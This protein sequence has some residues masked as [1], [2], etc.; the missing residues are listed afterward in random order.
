MEWRVE[1]RHGV[2][3]AAAVLAV[4][5]TAV[6]LAVPAA[7]APTVAAHLLIVDT[8]GFGVLF[9]V[10]LVLFERAEG[11]RAIL[12]AAPL[13]S[14]EYVG[15]KLG[16]LTC[17]AA[18]IAVP[19][20]LA[21]ARGR[22]G[23][24]SA[25]P[26]VL[27]GV[28]LLSLL[29]VGGVLAACG[30]SAGPGVLFTRLPLVAPLVAAPLVH[31]S[32]ALDH[33][34]LYL[35]P[36]TGGADLIR[37][38]LL[39]EAAPGA[40]PLAVAVLYLLVWIAGAAVLAGRAAGPETAAAVP[41]PGD[42]S[43]LRPELGEGRTTGTARARADAPAAGRVPGGTGAS[44]VPRRG[45]AVGGLARVDLRGLL[46][47]PMLVALLLGP[48]L[49]AL[50]LRWG[51]PP[52]S[53][54]LSDRYGLDTA[55]L[56]P[57][58]LAALVVLHVPMMIGAIAALRTVEDADDGTQ[59]LYRVS[60]LGLPR[61]L[62][63]RLAVASIAAAGGLAAAVPLSGLAA[64]V[65][66][67]RAPALVAAVALAALQAPLFVLAA[68][69]FAPSKIETLVLVKVAGA[70]FTLTPVAVWWLPGRAAWALAP[71]PLF[72]PTAVLPGFGTVPWP[73]GLAAGTV[74]AA[75][76]GAWLVRRTVRRLEGG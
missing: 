63:Y 47:D 8:A 20:T 52:V 2:P 17:L 74:V 5:W 33:P 62:A 7:S 23:A 14:A 32:G 29:L 59:L 9:A 10:V 3:A 18:A 51:Y 31:V 54:F 38:G 58:L 39:P 55:P 64:G 19:M 43:S 1:L 21:A 73:A 13:R 76:S 28:V 57:V 61:Y 34:L 65:P 41:P 15:A 11:G 50:A 27:L 70:V 36:T 42:R 6:L 44:A 48:V 26:P 67:E 4:L 25:L 69:A 24:G 60:P 40:G 75:L 53:G 45:G 12:A 71:L 56:A 66:A 35:V 16:V 68:T 49:L 22:P 46:R 37:A 30:R 72:W